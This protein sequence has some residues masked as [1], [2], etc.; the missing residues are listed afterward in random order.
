MHRGF[1]FI[2]FYLLLSAFICFFF[3]YRISLPSW[4][5]PSS[6]FGLL[7]GLREQ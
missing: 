2:C 5:Y 1:A 3:V 7:I 6:I 4:L